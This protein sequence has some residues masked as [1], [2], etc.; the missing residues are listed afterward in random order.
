M[1]FKMAYR[2]VVIIGMMTTASGL[3][4]ILE[5]YDYFFNLKKVEY[6]CQ[7]DQDCETVDE[8]FVKIM[9]TKP[10]EYGDNPDVINSNLSGYKCI[11]KKMMVQTEKCYTTDCRDYRGTQTVT[12]SGN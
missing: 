7:K 6:E 10:R 3:P 1:T 9:N 5:I 11:D 12:R 8:I 4:Q 2:V